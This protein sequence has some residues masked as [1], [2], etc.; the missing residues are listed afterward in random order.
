MSLIGVLTGISFAL[1][2][3]GHIALACIGAGL[4]VV[5]FKLMGV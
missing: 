3:S 1:L 5:F 2:F 4:C